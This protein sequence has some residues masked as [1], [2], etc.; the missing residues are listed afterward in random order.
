MKFLK[1]FGLENNQLK[2]YKSDGMN[3]FAN[4]TKAAVGGTPY[5]EMI[6][7]WNFYQTDETVQINWI[8][9]SYIDNLSY[10]GGLLDIIL[11]VPAVVM[12]IYTFRLNEI[13]VTFYTAQLVQ[14]IK[15]ENEKR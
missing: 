7:Y 2:P 9:Y 13:S 5:T 11:L 15:D 6:Q 12:A 8:F 14:R 1:F 10:L 4:N 3:N